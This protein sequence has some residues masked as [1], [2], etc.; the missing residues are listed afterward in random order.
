MPNELNHFPQKPVDVCVRLD[1]VTD[2]PRALPVSSWV[3]SLAGGGLPLELTTAPPRDSPHPTAERASAPLPSQG[4]SATVGLKPTYIIC[5][6]NMR[7]PCST[8][9]NQTRGPCE[10]L[11]RCRPWSWSWWDTGRL[12]D[13]QGISPRDRLTSPGRTS[14]LPVP[15]PH[16]SASSSQEPF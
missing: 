10:H 14:S 2:A 6:M 3:P 13:P 7:A 11:Y 8:L 16:P 5:K 15:L 12:W 4:A 9:L 1:G